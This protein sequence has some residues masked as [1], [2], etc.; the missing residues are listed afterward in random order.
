MFTCKKSSPVY[1]MRMIY[2]AWCFFYI[3]VFFFHQISY[4]EK[5]LFQKKYLI[6]DFNLENVIF[7][8]SIVLTLEHPYPTPLTQLLTT[9]VTLKST[10]LHTPVLLFSD[11]V[12]TALQ[13]SLFLF[14]HFWR[15]F[16][17]N[18]LTLLNFEKSRYRM[19]N[20]PKWNK[21]HCEA[22]ML[23]VCIEWCDTF[24]EMIAHFLNYS[25][26]TYWS[27]QK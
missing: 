13:R 15:P 4:P 25:S 5:C 20:R 6:V 17:F 14:N 27:V 16:R 8:N 11:N 22:S 10:V 18:F 21:R 12:S 26:I 1:I 19:T 23:V 7:L 24:K 9:A 3:Y 2:G